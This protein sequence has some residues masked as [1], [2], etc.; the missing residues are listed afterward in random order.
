MGRHGPQRDASGEGM[1]SGEDTRGPL[2]AL[3]SEALPLEMENTSE[4]KIRE[5]SERTSNQVANAGA[6]CPS[7]DGPGSAG[8]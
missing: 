2:S 5:A 7:S 6:A 8:T 1:Q 4:R 3:E